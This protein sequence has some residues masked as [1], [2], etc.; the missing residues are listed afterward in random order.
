MISTL[1]CLVKRQLAVNPPILMRPSIPPLSTRC[2]DGHPRRS[3]PRRPSLSLALARFPRYSSLSTQQTSL[4]VSTVLTDAPQ[5]DSSYEA[6]TPSRL[7]LVMRQR[8]RSER[9]VALCSRLYRFRGNTRGNTGAKP[10]L[11]PSR[12]AL[13]ILKNASKFLTVLSFDFGRAMRTDAVVYGRSCI[14]DTCA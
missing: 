12:A 9:S 3:F 5:L 2:Y 7:D 11:C 8:G 1:I 6:T 14:V 4:P 13:T 10:D